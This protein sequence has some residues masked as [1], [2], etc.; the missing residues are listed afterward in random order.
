MSGSTVSRARAARRTATA[1]SRNYYSPNGDVC[2]RQVRYR[3]ARMRRNPFRRNSLGDEFSATDAGPAGSSGAG[4][5]RL[6]GRP[7]LLGLR[8]KLEWMLGQRGELPGATSS[9]YVKR[10]RPVPAD[11]P[12]AMVQTP[13]SVPAEL[14]DVA[15]IGTDDSEIGG[16][17]GTVGRPPQSPWSARIE[18][19]L[20]VPA[21]RACLFAVATPMDRQTTLEQCAMDRAQ[22]GFVDGVLLCL[23]V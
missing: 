20:S 17:T 22:L 23:P 15:R 14:C 4:V 13:P 9:E 7:A 5:M 1:A 3:H 19:E 21:M 18:V 2:G 11:M 6:F 10:D 16:V 8:G 12:C